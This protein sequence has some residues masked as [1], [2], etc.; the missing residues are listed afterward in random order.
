[1][2]YVIYWLL[3]LALVLLTSQ[4]NVKFFS[5]SS[6]QECSSD[7]ITCK[8]GLCKP[9]FWKCDGVNDCGDNTDELNCGKHSLFF[10]I[11]VAQLWASLSDV[12]L[13]FQA[14]VKEENLPA[15]TRN[16]SRRRRSVMRETTVETVQMSSTVKEVRVEDVFLVFIT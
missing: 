3:V 1:M 13:F 16:V 2:Q 11:I 12:L 8:N 15:R 9:K 7:K 10:I 6:S 4:F 5:T 14:Y